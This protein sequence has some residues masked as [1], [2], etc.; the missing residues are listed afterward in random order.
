MAPH[1]LLFTALIS[2]TFLLGGCGEDK[3]MIEHVRDGK[4]LYEYYCQ[5]C[6]IKRGPGANFEK[7]DTSNRP[8]AEYQLILLM[9]FGDKKRHPSGPTFPQ[10][11]EV[12]LELIAQH[13]ME[14]QKKASEK[15][16]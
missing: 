3:N 10:I 11:K 2:S 13:V 5:D 4:K 16:Q 15:Q 7:R 9:Q 8:L 6:H 1:K 14:L 12:Q